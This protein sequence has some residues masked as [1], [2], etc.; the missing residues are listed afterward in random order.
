NFTMIF[1]LC[2]LSIAIP[3]GADAYPLAD[4]LILPVDVDVLAVLPHTHYLG[5]TLEGLAVFPGGARQRLLYIPDWDFNWQGDYRYSRPVH[6]PAGT[7]LQMR[8]VYDNSS[9][10]PRNPNQP[11]KEV[12]YGPQSSDEM[13][14]L[15][16]QVQTRNTNDLSRLA[17]ASNENHNKT[18][19]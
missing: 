18:L 1:T 6:L 2:S 10:N 9:A 15:W 5:K 11:P 8:Y 16:F 3:P 13:G 14:E 19:A 7:V 4:N 17:E 12:L